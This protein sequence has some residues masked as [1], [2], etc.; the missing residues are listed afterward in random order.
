MGGQ[1]QGSIPDLTLYSS[2]SLPNISLGR[3]A[4]MPSHHTPVNKQTVPLSFFQ[5]V[6]RVT[7]VGLKIRMD[8]C[9][10]T[11]GVDPLFFLSSLLSLQEAMSIVNDVEMRAALA[12]RM[13]L[14]MGSH[15]H[16]LH[17]YPAHLAAPPP[18][19]PPPGSLDTTPSSSGG[20][21]SSGS[22]GSPESPAFIH[23]QMQLLEQAG[24]HSAHLLMG[25]VYP[26][27]PITDAQVRA[28]LRF[29]P[30][31]T[32]CF[33]NDARESRARCFFFLVGSVSI[34]S[35]C[36][37][38]RGTCGHCLLCSWALAH[39]FSRR[40]RKRKRKKKEKKMVVSWP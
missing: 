32:Q 6:H 4:A 37:I 40:W 10:W 31:S 38:W 29:S 18:P 16:L 19:H 3:P 7:T 1:Q 15:P 14:S 36:V 21:Y 28:T 2:P 12:A 25:S 33:R 24:A 20:E 30:L 35:C 22:G 26:N 9:K 34:I 5:K 13:G 17:Y 23:K 39:T 8:L 27:G 11:F